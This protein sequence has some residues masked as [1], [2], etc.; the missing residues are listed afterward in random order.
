MDSLD[1]FV[2]LEGNL[3]IEQRSRH[4]SLGHFLDLIFASFNNTFADATP[5]SLVAPLSSIPTVA[6]R[7]AS[8]YKY[9]SGSDFVELYDKE[10]KRWQ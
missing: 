6:R 7:S 4:R 5:E 8:S 2:S 1:K 3:I 9:T 10:N